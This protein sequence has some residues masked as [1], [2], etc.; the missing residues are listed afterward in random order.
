MTIRAHAFSCL[1]SA[2]ATT[3]VVGLAVAS[4]TITAGCG[5]GSEDNFR[6]PSELLRTACQLALGHTFLSPNQMGRHSTIW[7]IG[8]GILP[9]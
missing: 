7:D 4:A 6:P 8:T 5:S 1:D 9:D 2:L 3:V